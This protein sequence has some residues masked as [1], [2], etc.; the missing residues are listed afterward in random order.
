MNV[1]K[2]SGTRLSVN[3]NPD[4]VPGFLFL[5]TKN[6]T[7]SGAFF[8]L[9]RYDTVLNKWNV[10]LFLTENFQAPEDL[11]KHSALQDI[12]FSSFFF[13]LYAI[14]AVLYSD[15]IR[16]TDPV[17]SGSDRI[18]N[19]YVKYNRN[20]DLLCRDDWDELLHLLYEPVEP[21]SSKLFRLVP[22][23]PGGAATE[24]E[25]PDPFLTLLESSGSDLWATV[26]DPDP[27]KRELFTQSS[28]TSRSISDP[29]ESS[30]SVTVFRLFQIRLWPFRKL[31]IRPMSQCCVSGSR[32]KR[33]V[34]EL[35][36][37]S[38]GCSR[39]VSAPWE[40]SGSD[41]WASVVD[42]DPNKR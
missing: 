33:A 10:N 35:F 9:N 24:R 3:P 26:V 18:R 1:K 36:T 29:F 14:I 25:I 22:Q 7:N 31:R 11:R 8:P 30:G 34:Y 6:W 21:V 2:C 12:K 19:T 5:M 40:S 17:E 41:L 27:N 20:S 39:S 15:R 28:G 23:L 38:S 32:K 37:Q 13:F 16:I 42:P 4:P